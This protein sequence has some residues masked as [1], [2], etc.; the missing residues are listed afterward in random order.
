MASWI[1]PVKTISYTVALGTHLFNTANTISIVSILLL[2]K[3]PF[4]S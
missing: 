1:D 3:L 4:F 2:T